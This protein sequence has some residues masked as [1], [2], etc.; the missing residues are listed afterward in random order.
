MNIF[1][2]QPQDA[3]RFHREVSC[4]AVRLN[5]TNFLISF[6]IICTKI[7]ECS[8]QIRQNS[9]KTNIILNHSYFIVSCF[10]FALLLL[11]F[12]RKKEILQ[13]LPEIR[14]REMRPY[15]LSPRT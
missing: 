9:H 4:D 12:L 5:K 15:I 10:V 13:R 1:P 7:E 6:K 8:F 3:I 2:I 14:E 11:N